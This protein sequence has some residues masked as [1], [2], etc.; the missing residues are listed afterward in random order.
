MLIWKF[1][2]VAA[3]FLAVAVF[4]GQGMLSARIVGTGDV[5]T[6]RRLIT[7]EARFQPIGGGLLLLGLIFG[8]IT[9]TSAGFALTAPWLLISYGLVLIILV[10]GATFHGPHDRSLKK[11]AEESPEDQPS[12][13][14]S[15]FIAA[16]S[17]RVVAAVD[18]F[19]W[20][21]LVFVMVVKPF[22]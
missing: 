21:A 5:H 3:M 20:L 10:I 4:V 1:L 8:F 16:P 13:E 7:V 22:T 6:I 18:G 19:V 15:A 9:A 2:H 12:D 14:L 11:L 17:A